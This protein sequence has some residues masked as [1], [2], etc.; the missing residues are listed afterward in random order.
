MQPDE[1]AHAE[2]IANRQPLPNVSLALAALGEVD[3]ASIPGTTARRGLQTVIFGGLVATH[4]SLTF[5]FSAP[6]SSIAVSIALAADQV[7]GEGVPS[8]PLFVLVGRSLYAWAAT[9]SLPATAVYALDLVT[10]IDDA[11]GLQCGFRGI[12]IAW[13]LFCVA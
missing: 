2:A 13:H 7:G 9:G 12:C 1:I 11:D 3:Y 5:T 10:V 6:F 8:H 4:H